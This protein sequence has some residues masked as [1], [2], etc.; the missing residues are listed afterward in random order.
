MGKHRSQKRQKQSS[1]AHTKS[2]QSDPFQKTPSRKP[3]N[4][5]LKQ[6]PTIPF[7]PDHRILLIGEGDFSFSRALIDH[8][9]CTCLCATS[10]DSQSSSL[11]KY[12]QVAATIT[13]IAKAENCKVEYNIDATKL[14][15]PGHIGSGSKILRRGNWDRIV[16]NF[17]HVGGLTKDVNRQVRANQELVVGFFRAALPL[18]AHDGQII[19]TI[20]EGEPY[21]LWS[22]RDLARHVG[23]KVQRSF[24][25]QAG[26]YP[27]YKHARTLGNIEGSGGWKGED[28][29]ARTYVFESHEGQDRAPPSAKRKRD[30][31]DSDSDQ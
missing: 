30:E 20:F 23:L 27:G 29:P 11:S 12:P 28:R 18:L 22:V 10:F 5:E 1:K 9:S 6:P 3:E 4:S 26:A 2:K 16:F 14:G 13:T 15:H 17:P 21:E 25:F 19:L 24:R 7:S 8:H 31:S